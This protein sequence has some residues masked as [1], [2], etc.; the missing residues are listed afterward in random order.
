MSIRRKFLAVGIFISLILAGYALF[1]WYPKVEQYSLKRAETHAYDKMAIATNFLVPLLINKDSVEIN[2]SL[3]AIVYGKEDWVS[4]QLYDASDQIIS[5]VSTPVA[6]DQS[7]LVT[8]EQDLDFAG[9]SLGKL[10]LT[11]DLQPSILALRSQLYQFAAVFSVMI[12]ASLAVTFY[13]VDNFISGP[14]SRLV[15][16]AANVAKGD[17]QSP[18]P[19]TGKDE[20]GRLTH[21]FD[22]MRKELEQKTHEIERINESLESEIHERT[23]QL[24]QEIEERK[25]AFQNMERAREDAFAA[26]L[27]KSEFLAHMSHELRSPLNAVIGFADAMKHEVFGKIQPPQY[28]EY[29]QNIF[30]SGQHL[31]E[32][33]NDILDLSAVESGKLQLEETEINIQEAYEAVLVM[34]RPRAENKRL[35]VL[36]N[37][38]EQLPAVRADERRLKQIFINLLTNAIKFTAKGGKIELTALARED[39]SLAISL[40][41][42]GLGMN[43][44]EVAIAMTEFG[45]VRNTS[46][47]SHEGTGLGLPLSLALV[48]EHDGG[49]EI[50]S[51]PGTG[52]TVTIWFPAN[53]VISL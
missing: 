32:L 46:S 4:L 53:R 14:A 7:D 2:E 30:D 49:L 9:K 22:D 13:F 28:E 41:D 36:N 23:T 12:L 20:L 16:A 50:E 34:M 15:E 27:T 40:T 11:V 1:V 29:I 51:E 21:A 52:T 31:L 10:K 43:E 42:T 48:K 5:Q 24:R 33:I 47:Q 45:Q 44:Q 35:I 19:K 18:L 8:L 25:Q 39:G 17:Y 6:R 37:V 38:P 26:N 3:R